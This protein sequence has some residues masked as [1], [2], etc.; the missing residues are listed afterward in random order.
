MKKKL[1]LIKIVL[2]IV[3][4]ILL[5]SPILAKVGVSAL[6]EESMKIS[7][8]MSL[9]FASLIL[10]AVLPWFNKYLA[11]FMMLIV[12]LGLSRGLLRVGEQDIVKTFMSMKFGL[13]FGF[14][15]WLSS[16]WGE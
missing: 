3:V 5:A 4:L 9:V 6:K 10:L 14:R 2:A 8:G 11:S 12:G 13:G 7:R 15:G 16:A 1:Y